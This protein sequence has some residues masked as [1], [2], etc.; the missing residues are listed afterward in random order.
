MQNITTANQVVITDN[1]DSMHDMWDMGKKA[2][3][4]ML[5]HVNLVL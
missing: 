1:T 5:C 2:Q 3:E 4:L